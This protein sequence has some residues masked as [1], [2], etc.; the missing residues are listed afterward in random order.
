MRACVRVCVCVCVCV[1]EV[2]CCVPTPKFPILGRP[3]ITSHCY[4]L[5]SLQD[6]SVCGVKCSDGVS[7]TV[8]DGVKAVGVVCVKVADVCG[9]SPDGE[10]GVKPDSWSVNAECVCTTGDDWG[11]K[12]D[13]EDSERIKSVGGGGDD[14]NTEDDSCAMLEFNLV[15]ETVGTGDA[16]IASCLC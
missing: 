6:T 2:E 7:R 8:E 16:K 5:S 11:I 15:T 4:T 12:V 14:I 13:G 1:R 3:L 10:R 9:V